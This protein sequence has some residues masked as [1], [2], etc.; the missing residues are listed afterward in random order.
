MLV[1]KEKRGIFHGIG[2][3]KV[4]TG[5][6]DAV[7]PFSKTILYYISSSKYVYIFL[8]PTNITYSNFGLCKFV[9]GFRLCKIKNCH[10][11]KRKLKFC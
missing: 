11:T 6:V 10:I 1:V 4:P 8:V 5:V 7:C 9:F 2:V 3:W